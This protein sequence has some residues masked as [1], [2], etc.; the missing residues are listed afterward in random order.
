LDKQNHITSSCVIAGNTVYKNSETVFINREADNAEFLVSVY[1]SLNTGYARF[2]KMD[3]LS[4]LGWLASEIL[5]KNSFDTT[6]YQPEE[7]GVLLSN[8]S[9]S[10]D[11]DIKYLETVKEVA[12]PSVFVY[13]LPNIMIG[14]ICLRN[15]FKGES[16]FFVF[17]KFDAGFM[18]QYVNNLLNSNILQA[19]ICGWV[20]LLG[21][22]YKAAL[23]LVEK[24]A[25]GN[26]KTFNRQNIHSLFE[27]EN[28]K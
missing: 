2:Y 10:L 12:S 21:K 1:Q 16:A 5:L 7:M 15:H 3:N 17:E 4:K 18:E 25:A 23:Y 26:A 24:N 6:Q 14:E 22:E 8:A 11:T 19:C 28:I 13:T 9:A 20:E 27:G